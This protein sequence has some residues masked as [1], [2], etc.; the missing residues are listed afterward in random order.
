MTKKQTHSRAKQCKRP[1]N[2]QELNK[3]LKPLIEATLVQ[4]NVSIG[5]V[6]A[7]SSLNPFPI[8]GRYVKIVLDGNSISANN[9]IKILNFYGYEIDFTPFKFEN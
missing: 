5:W 4:N 7:D 2:F 8:S 9:Y 1:A 6:C 3:M